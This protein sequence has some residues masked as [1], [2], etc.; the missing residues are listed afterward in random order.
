LSISQLSNHPGDIILIGGLATN[1]ATSCAH[2]NLWRLPVQHNRDGA[3]ARRIGGNGTGLEAL[4]REPRR[5]V[6]DATA[7]A[8][9]AQERQERIG[10]QLRRPGTLPNEK[11]VA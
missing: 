11:A 2:L 3:D 4:S 1:A 5:A 8:D 9:S 7:T 10:R 6:C